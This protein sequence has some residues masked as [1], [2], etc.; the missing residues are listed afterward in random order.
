MGG[1]WA[2]VNLFPEAANG[3]E[4]A[5]TV[6]ALAFH[7]GTPE[8]LIPG[9]FSGGI[10]C[11]CSRLVVFIQTLSKKLQLPWSEVIEAGFQDVVAVLFGVYLINKTESY[12]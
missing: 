7:L 12:V 4:I 11:C 9:V 5:L 10:T 1:E 2:L 6:A 3:V 8:C